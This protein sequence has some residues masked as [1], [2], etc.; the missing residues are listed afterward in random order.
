MW[1]LNQ[2]QKDHQANETVMH[3]IKVCKLVL[4]HLKQNK[5]LK[6][7]AIL[8]SLLQYTAISFLFQKIKKHLTRFIKN[9]L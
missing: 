1:L 6:I 2:L 3:Y 4:D 8:E 7:N 5:P 9:T